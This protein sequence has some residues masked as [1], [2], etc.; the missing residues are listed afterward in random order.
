[1]MNGASPPWDMAVYHREMA[2]ARLLI[3]KC[4]TKSDCSKAYKWY[5]W[6]GRE[7]IIKGHYLLKHPDASPAVLNAAAGV[8][9][10]SP[11]FFESF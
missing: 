7:D 5:A 6:A 4:A 3:E 8:P 11:I 10:Q 2:I 9:Y 1:M